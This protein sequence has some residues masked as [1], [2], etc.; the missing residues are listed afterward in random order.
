VAA[1]CGG[2]DAIPDVPVVISTLTATA[3]PPPT[4]APTPVPATATPASTPKPSPT[5]APTAVPNHNPAFPDSP[6][7]GVQTSYTRD[8]D[9][10]IT[11]AVTTLVVPDAT[12]EDGDPITYTWAVSTG[13]ITNVGRKGTWVREIVGGQEAPGKVT[14]T[15]TDGKGGS[16]GFNA[17]FQ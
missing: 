8:E 2:G 6:F 9:G 7:T 17:D 1:A 4:D 14:V 15:A 13:T 12:D 16:A 3:T 10:T 5:P 11:G